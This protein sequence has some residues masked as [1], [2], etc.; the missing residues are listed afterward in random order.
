MS[1]HSEDRQALV[2]LYWSKVEQTLREVDIAIAGKAWSMAANRIYY[3]CFHAVTALLVHDG[4]EVGT[5][6]GAKVNF[7]KYYV[8]VGLATPEQGRLFSQLASL[9]E[10]ADYDCLFTAQEDNIMLYYPEAKALIEHIHRMLN[11]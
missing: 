2:K 4:H 7:G 11:E 1:L 5:H 8:K 10:K 9:R 6:L 3:A